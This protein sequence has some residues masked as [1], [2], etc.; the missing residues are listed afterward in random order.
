M[1][2]VSPLPP[3]Q[4]IPASAGIGFRRAHE[5]EFLRSTP[6][7]RWLEVHSENYLCAGGGALSALSAVRERYP[8]SL[9]GVGLSL[10]GTD[11]LDA[12]H[13]RGLRDLIHT[14][15][16]GLVSEHLSWGAVNGRHTND[17]LPLPYTEE[18]LAHFVARVREVQDRLGRRILIENISSYVR[19]T[20]SRIPEA[21]FLEAVA[22]LS[23]CRLLFDV[24][25]IYV[26]ARNHGEDPFACV[27]GI[28]GELIE[29]IHLA[30]YSINRYQ[31]REILIDTHGAAVCD[32]VWRLYERL[33]ERI[34]P[35][36]TL[37]EW[38]TDVPPL[39]VL[40]AEA[41]KADAIL[42]AGRARAA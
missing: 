13:L 38:D 18:A 17:L 23:D 24:N 25:N 5:G 22:R 15:R 29:E 4:L 32:D 16:P 21:E 7:V 8:L 34:G 30:G 9:H 12:E 27:D 11:P 41:R 3:P 1:P 40:L 37:I 42:E 33:V 35:R 19:F 2:G 36:P 31:E 10:G 39:P 28:P 6:A 26:N 20:A 14:V